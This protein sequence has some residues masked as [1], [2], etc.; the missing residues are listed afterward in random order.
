MLDTLVI[1]ALGAIGLQL[2]VRPLVGL[3]ALAPETQTLCL[4]AIRIV[5]LGYLFVGA[6]IAYQG[7]FQALGCGV[8]SLIVSLIRLIVAALPLAL[9]LSRLPNAE[10][11]MWAAFP[12][13]EGLALAVAL[14]LM[15]RI[16]RERL[17]PQESRASGETDSCRLLPENRPSGS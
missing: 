14:V 15:R 8:R 3:F 5:T 9:L 10:T 12:V 6:N 4:R 13:A 2:F 16:A 1:M 17:K 11:V 7:I